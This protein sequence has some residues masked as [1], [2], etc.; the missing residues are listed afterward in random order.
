MIIIKGQWKSY[1]QVITDEKMYIA[2]RVIDTAKPLHG[3][4]IEYIGGYTPNKDVIDKLCETLNRD[5]NVTT[6]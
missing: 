5:E 1:S 2:G 6:T 3:G 4:N